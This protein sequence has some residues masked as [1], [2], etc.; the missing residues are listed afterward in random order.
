MQTI[1][2]AL[3]ALRAA[4]T[5]AAEHDVRYY[6]NGLYIDTTAGRIV[7]TDGHRLFACDG[8]KSEV[9]PL[10]IPNSLV[11]AALA[12]FKGLYARGKELG[13]V[14][15]EMTVDGDN[16]SI[17]TPVGVVSEKAIDGRF[18]DYKAAVPKADDLGDFAPCGMNP[19]YAYDAVDAIK[20]YRNANKKVR[21]SSEESGG[22]IYTRG[23]LPAIVTDGAGGCVAVVMPMRLTV[24][25]AVCLDWLH[26]TATAEAPAAADAVAA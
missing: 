24:D 7:A 1:N 16:L 22:Y 15:V 17:K 4:R 25:A 8:P 5:H 10:I 3:N 13:A 18:P 26:A 19:A 11:D 6:L 21:N 20:I 9:P 2:L 23:E 12:Q 14:H